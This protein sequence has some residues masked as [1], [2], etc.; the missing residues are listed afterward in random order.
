MS[1][2]IPKTVRIMGVRIIILMILTSISK[3][4]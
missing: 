3:E 4:K 1:R 2:N